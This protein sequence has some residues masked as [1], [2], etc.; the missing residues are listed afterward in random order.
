LKEPKEL[1]KGWKSSKN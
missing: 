1:T